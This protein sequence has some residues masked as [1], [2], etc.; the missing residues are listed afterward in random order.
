AKD[1]RRGVGTTGQ[2]SGQPPYSLSSAKLPLT[3][4]GSD[5]T[6]IFTA[7]DRK[8]ATSRVV[9]L[10]YQV[11]HIEYNIQ[12]M[13]VTGFAGER[14]ADYYASTWLS[15]VLPPEPVQVGQPAVEIPIPLRAFPLPPSL[16]TQGAIPRRVTGANERDRL[17]ELLQWQ[18]T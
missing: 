11:N 13:K 8:D 17:K 2:D 18:Y 7:T 6:F 9:D 16:V 4:G 14:R 1:D 12:P 3:N 15:F 10:S 5:F